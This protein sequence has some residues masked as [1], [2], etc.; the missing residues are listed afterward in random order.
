MDVVILI[1]ICGA[2]VL[3]SAALGKSAKFSRFTSTLMALG[4]PR[5][6][7]GIAGVGVILLESATALSLLAGYLPL[8]GLAMMLCAGAFAAGAIVA[9]KRGLYVPCACFGVASH[10]LGLRNVGAAALLLLASLPLLASHRSAPLHHLV[11]GASLAGYVALAATTLL[12]VRWVLTA[13]AVTHLVRDRRAAAFRVDP[14][15]LRSL[16][17]K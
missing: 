1:R 10:P 7:S 6:P 17:G 2:A 15:V 13:G 16:E 11:Y 12:A 14:S 8:A 9:V 3:G 4:I 5:V